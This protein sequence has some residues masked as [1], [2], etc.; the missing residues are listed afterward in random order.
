MDPELLAY[1]DRKF[2]ALQQSTDNQFADLRQST[3]SRFDKVDARLASL[4]SRV[5]SLD[6]RVASL[7]SRVASLDSR[8]GSLDSRVG[9]L[10]SRVGSLE[11]RFD[12][13]ETEVRHLG[14]LQEQ[15]RSEVRLVAE[16]VTATNESLD[17]F[18]VEIRQEMKEAA[19]LNRRAY[20]NLDR[21][22][23]ALEQT[24]PRILAG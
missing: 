3:D 9:S 10:D 20:E 16:G 5:A 24:R 12:S 6:S 14:V 2:A 11:T 21:R 17:R 23:T 15:T 22:V 18:R 19:T 1:L 13:L 7:D 4:D 8:V